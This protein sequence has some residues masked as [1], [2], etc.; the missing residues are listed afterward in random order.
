MWPHIMVWALT[1]QALMAPRTRCCTFLQTA[2]RPGSKKRPATL[3]KKKGIGP[4]GR[5][6]RPTDARRRFSYRSVL[7]VVLRRLVSIHWLTFR[8]TVA[9]LI[10]PA[11]R[12]SPLSCSALTPF[13]QQPPCQNRKVM[14]FKGLGAGFAARHRPMC[15][16]ADS[17]CSP[18]DSAHSFGPPAVGCKRP[19]LL[20]PRSAG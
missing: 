7:V 17:S 19:A 10:S 11:V 1:G 13:T 6:V 14:F 16:L 20:K 2:I 8:I 12:E 3:H 5:W 15:P 9:G 4:A 18:A